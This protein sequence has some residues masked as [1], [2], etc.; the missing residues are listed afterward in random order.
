MSS[1]SLSSSSKQR[2]RYPLR[3]W[4]AVAAA[5]LAFAV[6]VFTGALF[7]VLLLPLV[8]FYVGAIVSSAG[9]LSAAHEYARSQ[10]RVEP[11]RLAVSRDAP[12]P[13]PAAAPRAA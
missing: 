5:W 13:S 11:S 10:G 9:L 8:P 3:A 4:L 6:L 2:T 7:C 1:I 12:Q